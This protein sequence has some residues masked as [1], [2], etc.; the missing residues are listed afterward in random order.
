[1]ETPPRPTSD[2]HLSVNVTLRMNNSFF[3]SLSPT[4]R[5]SQTVG[6]LHW[7]CIIAWLRPPFTVLVLVPSSAEG[8]G[9]T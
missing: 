4:P 2:S 7:H 1:M 6:V 5:L 8:T 9:V 3:T